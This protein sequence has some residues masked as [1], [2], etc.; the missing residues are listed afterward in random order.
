MTTLRT[1]LVAAAA[2]GLLLAP[3][4]SAAEPTF[5]FSAR[6]AGS[7]VPLVVGGWSGDGRQA[8][9]E[10]DLLAVS[11]SARTSFV[12][13]WTS[14]VGT[15][16]AGFG[17]V[18]TA[19][20][21]DEGPL[22]TPQHVSVLPA[23]TDLHLES[24]TRYGTGRWSRWSSEKQRTFNSLERSDGITVVVADCNGFDR[25]TRYQVQHRLTGTKG[26]TDL[27]GVR[28]DVTLGGTACG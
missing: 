13:T 16:P 18:S 10:L 9:L 6:T 4:S 24:R 8:S 23:I 7:P 11:P 1:L 25:P 28:L 19:Q 12:A 21:T 5:A 20:F 17:T 2:A 27:S 3:G 26:G 14:D 15:L 22:G